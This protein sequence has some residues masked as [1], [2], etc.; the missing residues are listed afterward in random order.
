MTCGNSM[1]FIANNKDDIAYY[2]KSI[3]DINGLKLNSVEHRFGITV[4]QCSKGITEESEF[5][6]IVEA[7]VREKS[8][9]KIDYYDDPLG[10]IRISIS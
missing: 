6:R 1:H 9:G 2:I 7:V 3:R 8:N 5:A 4:I 10:G